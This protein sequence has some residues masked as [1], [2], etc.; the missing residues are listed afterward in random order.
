M[1]TDIPL[2]IG[3]GGEEE[4]GRESLVCLSATDQTS[5]VLWARETG[6]LSRLALRSRVCT[7]LPGTEDCGVPPQAFSSCHPSESTVSS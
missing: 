4:V 3:I 5:T 1:K 2:A 7:L 6:L